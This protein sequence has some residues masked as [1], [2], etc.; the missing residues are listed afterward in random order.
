MTHYSLAAFGDSFADQ[1]SSNKFSKGW[2][3][4]LSRELGIR[5]DRCYNCAESGTSIWWAYTNLLAFL[6]QG[7]TVD[8]IVFCLS[9][10]GRIPL[11]FTHSRFSKNFEQE[12]PMISNDSYLYETASDQGS[13]ML[14]VI[15]KEYLTEKFIPNTK[16]SM[17]DVFKIWFHVWDQPQTELDDTGYDKG[18]LIRFIS[19]YALQ[20]V[21]KICKFKNINLVLMFPFGIDNFFN[22]VDNMYT[23]DDV[24]SF[25][26]E[27]NDLLIVDNLDIVSRKEIN[28]DGDSDLVEVIWY[29]D[30]DT[31]SHTDSRCNHLMNENNQLLAK[32]LYSGIK[33]E[34]TGVVHLNEHPNLCYNEKLFKKYGEV[35]KENQS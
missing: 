24:S 19:K 23:S 1:I 4:Y 7:N 14:E 3:Y 13:H 16:Y 18:N 31:V 20:E 30:G 2:F 28:F 15:S 8:N 26:R 27:N 11:P 32:I 10:P 25:V 29:E 9:S 34:R 6:D 33:G 12:C 17:E 21:I 35:I 5:S 22:V